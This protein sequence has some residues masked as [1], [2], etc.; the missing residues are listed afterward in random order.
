MRTRQDL[1]QARSKAWTE[2]ETLVR[3]AEGPSGAARLNPSEI[4]S[5]A[6]EYRAL[7]SDLLQVRRDRLGADLERHLDTLAGRAHNVLHAGAGADAGMLSVGAL[8]LDF[9]G[10]LRRN[11]RFFVLATVLFYGPLA[12]GAFGAYSSEAYALAMLPPSQ[13]E[14]V[15]QMYADAPEREAS[16]QNAAMTGFYIWNNVGIAFRCFATG[17][18]AGLGSIWFL[19]TNGLFIGAVFGHLIR[20][21]LGPNILSFVA[22][23]SPWELTAITISG[24]AGL[25]MGL[26]L[27]ITHGR[28]RLGSLQSIGQ[29]LLRQVVGA[30]IF[31]FIAALIEAWV[32]PSPA[33]WPVKVAASVVGWGVVF[34]IIIGAGRGRIP[35]DVNAKREFEGA[36]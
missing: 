1:L 27:V 26:A 11:W 8:I 3:R 14:A 28:S 13:L 9:P 16:G 6:A 19:V 5:L 17:I 20:V 29:E 22:S 2:L 12:A 4:S 33:P 36:A 31:L 10:A 24:A 15:E 32:S 21:G 34:G 30:A 18:L 25:Q 23:H 35:A 7:A